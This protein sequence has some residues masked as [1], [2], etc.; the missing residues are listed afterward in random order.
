MLHT[1][2]KGWEF[3]GDFEKPTFYPSVLVRGGDINCHSFIK[4]GMIQFLHDC[5]HKMKNATVKIPDFETL[6]PDL[7]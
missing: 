3:N 1:V 5:S 7:Q 4:N 2:G 6:H